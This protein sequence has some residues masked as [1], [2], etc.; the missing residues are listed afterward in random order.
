MTTPLLNVPTWSAIVNGQAEDDAA[1]IALA[2]LRETPWLAN[3]GR[4]SSRD[5]DVVRVNQWREAF[6]MFTPGVDARTLLAFAPQ[7]GVTGDRTGT[8]TNGTLNAP[9]WLLMERIDRDAVLYKRTA[10]AANNA[11]DV[12]PDSHY[13]AAQDIAPAIPSDVWPD[14]KELEESG[15]AI[16]AMTTIG[17]YLHE[18]I[19]LLFIETYAG[20][21]DEPR[22]TY[23]RDQLGWF[24]A[25]LLPCGWEGDWPRGRLRVF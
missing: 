18:Y 11:L 16:Y 23:F 15:P 24:M 5:N 8:S 22:C 20:D 12:L 14:A 2:R 1:A 17:D 9:F 21:V 7:S 19:R 4:A 3:V 10:D 6:A 13:A 25:G